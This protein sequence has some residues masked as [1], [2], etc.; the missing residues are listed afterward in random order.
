MKRRDFV[1]KSALSAAAMTALGYP[2]SLRLPGGSMKDKDLPGEEDDS[3]VDEWSKEAPSNQ[4]MNYDFITFLPGVEYFLLGNGD[5]QAVVQYCKD[6]NLAGNSS[7]FGLTL[8]DPSHLSQK[9]TTFLFSPSY[10]FANTRMWVGIDGSFQ[11]V[12]DTSLVDIGWEHVDGIPL[13][14]LKWKTDTFEVEEE[15][16]VPNSGATL[17]RRGKVRNT[18]TS[19]H[20][21]TTGLMIYPNVAL[22]DDIYTD[23][24]N[25]TANAEGFAKLQLMS[26]EKNTTTLGRYHVRVHAGKLAPGEQTVADFAYRIADIDRPLKKKDF[27]SLW[28]AT[29]SYW[30]EKNRVVTGNG[31]IDH[32]WSIARTGMRAHVARNGKRDG[33]MWEYAMEWAGDDIMALMAALMAGFYDEAKVL[34]HRTLDKLVVADGRTVESSQVFP[35]QFTEIEQNGMILY[36]IWTY[37]AWTGD[38]QSIRDRWEK[39]RAVAELPLNPYFWKKTSGLLANEREFWERSSAFGVK[40]GFELAYQFW[41]ALGLEKIAELARKLGQ[42]AEAVRWRSAGESIR[43]SFLHN[44]EF[45]LVED[46]HLIKRRTLDGKWQRTFIPP[47]RAAMPEGTPIATEK[48]PLVEPDA[49]EAFPIIFEMID[50][51][52]PLSL[53]TLDWLEGLW[54]QRWKIGGYERYNSSSEPEPP[55]PWPIASL[56]IAEAYWEAGNYEKSMMVVDWLNEINGH[57]SGSWFEYYPEGHPSIGFIEWA[58]MECVRLVVDHILGVRPGLDRLVI[59]PR[60][61]P[62][63]NDVHAKIKVRG[64][65]I[66]LSIKATSSANSA[67]VNSKSVKF[68]NGMIAVPY[69]R[70]KEMNVQINIQRMN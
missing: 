12:D 33:G 24:K 69:T 15:I 26:L 2:M 13:V 45:K 38:Y 62:E 7:L 46:G 58:W 19:P 59:R 56:L 28:S 70:R 1:L 53:R 60:L 8:I 29:S 54:N 51:T 31:H 65:N 52:S 18:D 57:M 14:R 35:F 21:V 3:L 17:F 10:G 41:V 40:P 61:S 27:V 55:G 44:P 39:I 11:G 6:H 66:D 5:I 42:K 22:F 48:Y 23:P 68:E 32:L 4:S 50:P 49:S 25:G 63:M 67:S 37:A 64:T 9:Y 47:D 30:K 36:G 16:F 34:L 43:N 20:D